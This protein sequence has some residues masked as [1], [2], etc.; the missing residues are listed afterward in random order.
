MVLK[1]KVV[2]NV[3]TLEISSRGVECRPK[4]EVVNSETALVSFSLLLE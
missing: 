2:V 4:R 3:E 1:K